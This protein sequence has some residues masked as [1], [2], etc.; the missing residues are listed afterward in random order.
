MELRSSVVLSPS[1]GHLSISLVMV[2]YRIHCRIHT[3]ASRQEWSL[4][5]F[6]SIIF[7][8]NLYRSVYLYLGI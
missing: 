4:L 7:S 1:T 8:L 6:N 5:V 3:T 2:S